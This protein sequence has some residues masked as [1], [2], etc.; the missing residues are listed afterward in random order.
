MA[1][2]ITETN[3]W[4]FQELNNIPT[5]KDYL[6][7]RCIKRYGVLRFYP[8]LTPKE[9]E[10]FGVNV[11]QKGWTKKDIQLTDEMRKKLLSV[12]IC[13]KKRDNRPV[14][15]RRV[16]HNSDVYEY[17]EKA[18]YVFKNE[19]GYY[20][21]GISKHPYKRANTLSNQAGLEIEVVGIWKVENSFACERHLHNIF[22][23]YR[24]I[25]EWFVFDNFE[26]QRVERNIPFSFVR[27]ATA[28]PQ[29][30]FTIIED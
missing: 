24:R 15:Y 12:R 27:V 30:K 23:E 7:Q 25:G 13:N 28:E 11:K 9:Q 14:E 5:Y 10:I 1:R 21:I 26:V 18:L 8:T 19:V 4:T 29:N 20:K 6:I 2:Y 22:R 16:E 3:T 17:D